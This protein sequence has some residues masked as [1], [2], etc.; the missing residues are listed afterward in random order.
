[1]GIS[2]NWATAHVLAFDGW[3][4]NPRV[5]GGCHLD[6]NVLQSVYNEAQGPLEVKSSTILD[7]VG[8]NQCLSCPMA[9]PF[10]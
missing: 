6:A 8:S 5:A 9:M 3:P 2:R 1:M 7:P 10:F 4:Q